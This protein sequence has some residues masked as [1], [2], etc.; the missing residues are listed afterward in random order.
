MKTLKFVFA[1][2][3]SGALAFPAIAFAGCN[4]AGA[5]P[6]K[7][8]GD[9]DPPGWSQ[10]NPGQGGSE[11]PGQGP[12]GLDDESAYLSCMSAIASQNPVSILDACDFL[13][14]EGDGN[15]YMLQL[16]LQKGK[17]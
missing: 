17:G 10:S 5:G 16:K 8:T 4:G 3:V 13:D 11:D 1:L 2:I 9:G 12:K 6:G 15:M 14:A 7:A